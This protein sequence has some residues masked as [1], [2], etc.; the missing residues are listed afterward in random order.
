MALKRVAASDYRNG[1]LN[2]SLPF[3][4]WLKKH[5]LE[6][7][8][9]FQS[10]ACV[11]VMNDEEWFERIYTVPTA[12]RN[13]FLSVSGQDGIFTKPFRT[14]DTPDDTGTQ[15]CWLGSGVLLEDALAKMRTI[16]TRSLD[17]EIGRRGIGM[18][19]KK[20]EYA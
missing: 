11:K 7:L 6:T 20:D 19:I 14:Q 5:N 16:A 12:Q 10:R 15:I 18:R 9:L 8:V 4:L 3:E 17:L 13:K 2:P 1:A